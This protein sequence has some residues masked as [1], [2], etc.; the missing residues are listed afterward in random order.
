MKLILIR[1]V[2]TIANYQKKYIGSTKSDYTNRGKKQIIKILKGIENEKVDKI[3][4]SPLPRAFKLANK[5]SN[6]LDK[7]IEIQNALKELNFGVFENK[8]YKEVKAEYENEWNE[9]INDYINYKIPKGESLKEVYKRVSSFLD[10]L[11]ESNKTFLLVTHGGII[12]TILTYL[13]DLNINDRWHFKIPPGSIVEIE[14]KDNYGILTKL[15]TN[16][17]ID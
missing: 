9:W 12:Q 5:I 10:S 16:K 14:Y 8:T 15:N 1:H 11:K 13:L 4:S 2:E 6:K 7:D 17:I 3:Y